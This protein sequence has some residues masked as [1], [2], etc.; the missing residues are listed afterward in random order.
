MPQRLT[1]QMLQA[2]AAQWPQASQVPQAHTAPAS[3]A[4]PPPPPR[5]GGFTQVGA[6]TIYTAHTTGRQYD[7]SGPPPYPCSRCHGNHWSWQPCPAR[8]PNVPPQ[9]QPKPQP[10]AQPQ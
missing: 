9:P 1:P 8:Q 10:L 3:V 5:V 6:Q 4:L 7:V 2:Q